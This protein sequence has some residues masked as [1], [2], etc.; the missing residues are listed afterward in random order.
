MMIFL[1]I[2]ICLVIFISIQIYFYYQKYNKNKETIQKMEQYTSK[3]N[4]IENSKDYI[5]DDTSMER[6]L[7]DFENIKYNT[8]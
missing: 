1:I 7:D 4:N 3:L 6:L 2:F 5:L 8:F